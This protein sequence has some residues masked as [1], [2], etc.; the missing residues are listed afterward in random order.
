MLTGFPESQQ[1]QSR[2]I[3]ILFFAFRIVKLMSWR[4][5]PPRHYQLRRW[6]KQGCCGV[7]ASLILTGNHSSRLNLLKSGP[8]LKPPKPVKRPLPTDEGSAG[9]ALKRGMKSASFARSRGEGA[10]VLGDHYSRSVPEVPSLRL[11]SALI[12]RVN[13]TLTAADQS[14]PARS[15]AALFLKS[16]SRCK[17]YYHSHF[18]AT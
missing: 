3:S 16:H 11:R 2:E 8:E 10:W 18:N 12:R 17:G 14:Q 7:L 1:Q 9:D 4:A 6:L 5:K 15:F 13:V